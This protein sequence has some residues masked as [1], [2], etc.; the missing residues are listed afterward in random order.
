MNFFFISNYQFKVTTYSYNSFDDIIHNFGFK[1][2]LDLSQHN[3]FDWSKIDCWKFEYG[4]KTHLELESRFIKSEPYK[5]ESPFL[6]RL[7]HNLPLI[8]VEAT[9]LAKMLEDLCYETGMG[10]EAISVNGQHILE[11]TD[12]FEYMVKSNFPI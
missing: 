2:S 12:S 8:E 1:E 7:K 11:F 4:N 5:M 10:W 9:E 3:Y 6:I